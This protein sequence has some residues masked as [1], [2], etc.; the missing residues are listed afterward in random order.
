MK[1]GEVAKRTGCN[2]ETIRYYER[3]GVIDPPPRKGAYRDYSHTDLEHLRFVR[4]S[5]ELG[6]SLQEVQALLSLATRADENCDQVQR[7]AEEHLTNVRARVADLKRMET[8]LAALVER[9]DENRDG[10]CPVVM[11]LAGTEQAD[12]PDN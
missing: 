8:A 11:S 5:R 10:K 4:R 9:C 12:I 6:F 7:I 2:I 3:I 1:I